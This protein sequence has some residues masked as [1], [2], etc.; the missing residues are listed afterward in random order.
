MAKKIPANSELV[1]QV[2]YTPI[3]SEQ[4]D[5]SEIGLIFID[6]KTVT[7]RVITSSAV[8]HQFTIPA[9][10]DNYKLTAKSLRSP[11]QGQLLC[12]MPHMHLRGKSFQYDLVQPNGERETLLSVPN[13]DFNWQTTYR[14]LKPLQLQPGAQLFCT[15]HFDNSKDNPSNPDPEVD[16]SWG[17]QTDDEMMIGYFDYAIKIEDDSKIKKASRGEVLMAQ[18]DTN[19]DNKISLDE[20]PKKLAAYFIFIDANQDKLIT[21]EEINEADRKYRKKKSQNKK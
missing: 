2:H 7:H 12:L 8:N 11:L 1:F 17:D 15:A 4:E 13:Y 20:V 18:F 16:V 9:H 19:S 6:K 10:D 21:V 5:I 14:L 3:G